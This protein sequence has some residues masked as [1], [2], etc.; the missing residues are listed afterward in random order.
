MPDIEILFAAREHGDGNPFDGP[1][2]LLAHAYFPGS[3]IGGDAHFDE[4]ETWTDLTYRGLYTL[5]RYIIIIIIIIIIT[6]ITGPPN[7]LVLFCSLAS[8][9]VCRR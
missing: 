5:Y 7:G 4:D 1:G 2:S 6:L 8:V 3:G 9:V